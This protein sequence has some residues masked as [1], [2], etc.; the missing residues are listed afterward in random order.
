ML[1]SLLL[2]VGFLIYNPPPFPYLLPL[3][4]RPFLILMMLLASFAPTLLQAAEHIIL[5]GGPALR[6]FERHKKSSHDRYWGNFID[7]ASTRIGQIK[8]KLNKGDTITWLIYR[9]GYETRGKEMGEDLISTVISR[10]RGLGVKLVWFNDRD[11]L[12]EYLNHGGPR[13]DGVKIARLEYFGHSNKRTLMFDYSNRL[14]GACAEPSMLHIWNLSR[15]RRDIFEGGAYCKSWGCHSG[16]EYSGAF[17]RRTGR[18]MIGA[19]GK[20]DYSSGGIPRLSSSGGKWS[21]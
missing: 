13:S 21:Q 15:L 19:I 17:Y 12:L 3:V 20:T 5:S 9:P 10:A 1:S 8:P 18:R 16:E 4:R 11:E 6:Y 2:S 7:S 14:D